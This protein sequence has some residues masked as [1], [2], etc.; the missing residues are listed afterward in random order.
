MS[1]EDSYQQLSQMAEYYN[2]AANSNQSS[3]AYDMKN[4]MQNFIE[5]FI[6]QSQTS[7]NETNSGDSKTN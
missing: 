7:V 4:E 6:Y 3:A 1:S 5:N 2:M